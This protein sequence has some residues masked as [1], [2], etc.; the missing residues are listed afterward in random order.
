[1][2]NKVMVDWLDG[3]EATL[4]KE[5]MVAGLLEHGATIGQA[6]EFLVTRMLR[7]ILPSSVHIGT[8]KVIDSNGNS[9]KQIDIIIYD[10]RFALM[11]LEGGGLYFAEGV[12]AAIE[13]KSTM[14]QKELTASLEN[15][16]SVLELNIRGEHE[17]EATRQIAFYQA[18]GNLTTEDAQHRFWYRFHPATYVFSF[19]SKLSQGATMKHL[20]N[21]WESF[22]YRNSRYF[23]LLPRVITAGHTVCLT[24]DGR[25]DVSSQHGIEH[26]VTAFK[27]RLRFRWLAIHLMDTVSQRLGQR[28]FGE[29]FTYRITDYYPFEEYLKDIQ[30]AQFLS[31]NEPPKA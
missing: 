9:S 17:E 1:M 6:R 24:N 15:S 10:P 26:V 28:N 8:G 4:E 20:T 2:A 5:A 23:P 14:T 22:N 29:N 31:V 12:L 13:I 27:A 19:K 16:R 3:L 30:N 21:W 11:K 18:K 25:M 7:T